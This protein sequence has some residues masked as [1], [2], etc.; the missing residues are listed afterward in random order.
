MVVASRRMI[1]LESF[2][3]TSRL[4]RQAASVLLS[5]LLVCLRSGAQ[6]PAQISATRPVTPILRS[7]VKRALKAAER[8]DKAQ[9]EGRIDEALLAYDEAARYAPQ[10]AAIVGRG[11]SLRSKL[12]RGHV[13]NAER[14]ALAGKLS[15]AKEE[16]NIAMRIDPNNTVVAERIGQ[17]EQMRD[18]E[19]PLPLG[20]IAG[21]PHLKS[22]SGKHNFDLRG[23]TRTVYEQVATAFGIKVTFDP[24]LVSRNVRFQ[25]TDVDFNTAVSILG[26]QTGTFWRPIN[27]RLMFVAPDTI[28]KRRR[29]GLQAE[30]TFPLPSSVGPEEMTELLRLLREISGATHLEL[31]TRSRTITMRDSPQKLALASELINQV[32]RARGE[33]M[34]EIE[35][36]EVDRNKALQLGI[37]PPSSVKAFP[38]TPNDIRT[39]S[40]AKD[41]QNAMTI[42]GQ[43]FN[44]KGFSTVPGFT[45]VG[46]G[47]TT[48]L[49]TLPGVA[50]NFSDALNLV[51]SGRQVL[52]RAQDGKPATFFVGDRYPVTL[53]LLSGSLGAASGRNTGIPLTG[54]P[55]AANFPETSFTVGN[56]PVAL[57]VQDF[58][59][60]G[61]LD[62]A[63]V[64]ENDNT[65]SIL[66]NRNSGNFA[67]PATAS[68][69]LPA[70]ETA[71]VS[72][73]SG[74]FRNSP[75]NANGTPVAQTPDL[76][77]A[78]STSNNVGVFFGK[79]DGTFQEAL[80]SPLSLGVGK[81]PA[82]VVAAD[83]NGDGNLD[84]AVANQ[85]D[86]TISVFKGNGKGGFTPFPASPYKLRNTSTVSEQGP[87][88]MVVGNF[89]R[90]TLNTN[91]PNLPTSA[92]EVD[93]AVVNQKTNNVSILLGSV[94]ANDN[95]ILNE[96]ANS[97]V[98]VGKSPMAIA[99][100]D[101]NGDG[102]PDL[103]V[104]NQADNTVSILLGN[105]NANG[106]F[107][108]A[109]GSPLP[110]ATKP[111][112]ITIANFTG[113]NLPDLAVTN[114]GPSTLGIYIGLGSGAFSNRIEIAT[115]A[116]PGA[117]VSAILTSSGLPDVA[118]TAQG[119]TPKQGLV[120]I[121]QDSPTFANGTTPAQTPYP[122]SEYVDLGVKVKATPT[123]HR[124]HEVTL[125]LE[126]EIRALA[127]ANINGIPIISNRTLSQTVRV[128]EDETT[129]IGGLLD[130]E[131]TR[132]LVGLPGFANLSAAGYL[133]GNKTH[134]LKDTE[135]LILITPRRLR[136]PVRTARSIFAGRGDTGG[137]GSMGANAPLAP[138]PT[139]APMQLPEPP[140]PEPV[141]LP[142]QL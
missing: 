42:L 94:D 142:P 71:P 138:P 116:S 66:L 17:M 37:T 36:L 62:L 125:Q 140:E 115:P 82:A 136:D 22:Q 39:V 10:D 4:L 20:E 108:E 9:A 44:A 137:R 27:E 87:I 55:T 133:F 114:S 61:L 117:I 33:L 51:Q 18:E 47:Y 74:I 99:T 63:I 54:L 23:D 98:A 31:D 50:A 45:I 70:T 73:A 77:V 104:V 59:A 13:D 6:E 89:R 48:F 78:N 124:N 128:K 67:P 24:D 88:A 32:E 12:I 90:A 109:S 119:T 126:F 92:P 113:G 35:L 40:K 2:A 49:L 25:V 111:A 8:G 100:S 14:L 106:V 52:L 134:S 105:V 46:G 68:I 64:N 121:I 41:L 80:G 127:G 53:S 86:N 110:T 1:G 29:Y 103:A 118:L 91:N 21:I 11:A 123:L 57:A 107:S 16:L 19:P 122:A 38:I 139:P 120:T 93:L 81:T 135:F 56:N 7:D 75:T 58:N 84:F 132:S 5:V 76:I 97:P 30:Q 141:P 85:T 15:A 72:I 96:P 60:D 112:G 129:L 95:L 26:S 83:F 34:I 131:E 65:I 130:N 101:L 102:V 28:D 43:L 3:M 79:G 69:V